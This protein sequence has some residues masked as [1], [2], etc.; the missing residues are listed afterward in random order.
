M[1]C[2]VLEGYNGTIF[3]YGQVSAVM[4]QIIHNKNILFTVIMYV[5][6]HNVIIFVRM[7]Y[8]IIIIM[9]II[10]IYILYHQKKRQDT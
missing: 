2:S 5:I 7:Y 6:C 4:L 8:I 10:I 9:V 1:H 3:A